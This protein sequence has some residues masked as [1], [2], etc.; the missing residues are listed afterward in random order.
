MLAA[1]Q[2]PVQTLVDRKYLHGFVTDIDADTVAPGFGT[3]RARVT[4]PPNAR[5]TFAWTDKNN[6]PGPKSITIH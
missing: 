1:A 3:G 2:N 5:R 4:L 6:G